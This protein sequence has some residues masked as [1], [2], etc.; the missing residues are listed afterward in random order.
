MPAE[1]RGSRRELSKRRRRMERIAGK[2]LVIGLDVAR[3][4]QALTFGHG[5]EITGRQRI[6]VAP[7]H[8]GA[9][10][11]PVARQLCERDGL[12]RVVVGLEPAG[13]YWELAAE[14]F[15]REGLG[16]A[17]VHTLAVRREREATRYNLEK[18][19]PRDGD[20]IFELVSDGKFTET[21][22]F[23]TPQR[24]RLNALAR[25]Y[26][27]VRKRMAGERTRLTNFWTRVL[28]EVF[29]LFKA[30]EGITALALSQAM[31]PFSELAALTPA[32]WLARVRAHAEGRILHRRSTALLEHIRAA[33]QDPHRRAGEGIPVRIALAAQRHRLLSAQKQ[34]LREQLLALYAAM[35]EAVW[36]NSIPG[37]DPLYH[38][39]TLA[40]VGDFSLYDSPRAVVKLAGSEVNWHESGD[41]RGKSRIS[42]RG[43]SLLRAAAY[44]QA[45]KLVA[46]G[47]PVYRARFTHLLHR[48]TRPALA[49]RQVY[50]ALGNSYLRT[51]HQLVIQR[52]VWEAPS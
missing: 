25:E 20:V 15:E 7:Q 24:A 35:P 1:T 48:T 38:A 45:R 30:M 17:V 16:Y 31:L 50:T 43:R 40:L 32:E 49:I 46:N 23:D 12:E 21:R 39:L 47:N 14:G 3:R 29:E 27:L 37:S 2:T 18:Y 6:E 28:P 13:C 44:Q 22:L 52:K 26:L 8:L 42:Y 11:V 4:R 41:W 36:L 10:I 51:A 34:L 19:D 9:A 5:R 33:H